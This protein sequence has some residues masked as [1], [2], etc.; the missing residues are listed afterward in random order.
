MK[1][2]SYLRGSTGA[3][4]G[5]VAATLFIIFA[6]GAFFYYAG[7]LIG[8]NHEL[9]R[10]S[11]AGILSVAKQALV[12]PAVAL[13][14]A[15]L[16]ATNSCVIGSTLQTCP[17]NSIPYNDFAVGI[18][19]Q[20]NSIADQY[21]NG[22]P[23]I[24]LITYN[25]CAAQAVLVGL[26][27]QKINTTTAFQ[28]AQ[29][30]SWAVLGIGK[31]LQ[32]R[33]ATGGLDTYYDSAANLNTLNMLGGGSV[34]SRIGNLQQGY[35]N[36]GSP[37]N[38]YF[39][40]DVSYP[41]QNTPIVGLPQN[42]APAYPRPDQTRAS[43]SDS[44]FPA[45]ETVYYAQGY[46]PIT[47]MPGTAQASVVSFIPVNPQGTPHAID[48]GRVAAAITP[49]FNNS[50]SWVPPNSFQ[51]NAKANVDITGSQR[52]PDG[53]YVDAISCA[54]VGCG[55]PLA[56]LG[57]ILGGSGGP[58]DQAA[59]I[60]GGFVRVY[61]LPG[62]EQVSNPPLGPIPGMAGG[63]SSAFDGSGFVLNNA[64]LGGL[65]TVW[66]ATPIPQNPPGSVIQGNVIFAHSA[67]AK[68]EMAQ[69][70]QFNKSALAPT[71]LNY[72]ADV[73]N[74]QHHDPTLDPLSSP[75][76]AQSIAAGLNT[77]SQN[78][79]QGPSLNQKAFLNQ[80][81]LITGYVE[82]HSLVL[83][84]VHGVLDSNGNLVS[85]N[86][87]MTVTT[88]VAGANLG[89]GPPLSVNLT[90]P[91]DHQTW[92]WLEYVKYQVIRNYARD[93]SAGRYTLAA[94]QQDLTS[95]LKYSNWWHN[96][97]SRIHYSSPN[98]Y[99]LQT[100]GSNRGLEEPSSSQFMT[101]TTPNN[102]LTMIDSQ[103]QAA[104][105][106]FAGEVTYNQ[107]I[108]DITNRVRLINPAW[109]S[110][111]VITALNSP[112]ATLAPGTMKWLRD[113]G[114]GNLILTNT[115][116][117]DIGSAP[118]GYLVIPASTTLSNPQQ[119]EFI[120]WPGANGT[121]GQSL[122]VDGSVINTAIDGSQTAY[123]GDANVELEPWRQQ[124]GSIY[125]EAGAILYNATGYNNLV[126]QINFFSRP[127]T[128][129]NVN[130]SNPN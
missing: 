58:Q 89:Q 70:I 113:D 27:A 80:M 21:I 97:G 52:R 7:N 11:D 43:N 108:T 74:G 119:V 102:L 4:L 20:T 112:T 13:N 37:S 81:I 84:G 6:I 28:H 18:P 46:E 98:N 93:F 130:Y 30:V 75:N 94:L 38:I 78:L 16:L 29:A 34:I 77:Q 64:A 69:W 129:L 24:D 42:I 73:V 48:A 8:G 61:N 40:S 105:G 39:Y 88:E 114:S 31:V 53:T 124:S 83:D 127:T 23:A 15:Q 86:V 82:I 49:P 109:T 121:Q 100:T 66:F 87:A 45:G 106:Y 2:H 12:Q 71:A 57:G 59:R 9:N 26:E 10:A 111:N 36:P 107:M 5:M 122:K 91:P 22:Y 103:I 47:L 35:V 3:A 1:L 54:M 104:G 101:I 120:T 19:G 25:R 41:G 51:A 67:A 33:F 118:E 92:T 85:A 68:A 72:N 17:E 117:Q 95:G 56:G 62:M 99:E 110:T 44:E 76:T 96:D 116:P 128:N 126:G 90:V 63:D 115:C 32:Q 125:Y 123:T 50:L 60:P 55:D 14:D 65:S 79:L